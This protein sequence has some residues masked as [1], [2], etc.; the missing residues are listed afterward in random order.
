M[1]ENREGQ[2]QTPNHVDSSDA[3]VSGTPSKGSMNLAVLCHLLGP[4]TSFLGP[5]VL[6][7][8]KKDEDA[9]VESHGREALNFQLTFLIAYFVGSVLTFLNI[10]SLIIAV[11]WIG[12][13]VLSILATVAASKGQK[14]QYPVCLR[15]I[16]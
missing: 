14:Y 16:Q 2:S 9:Y 6:W 15:L 7:L 3:G 8:M 5:L 4:F 13:L 11:A 1:D 10:G 12:N